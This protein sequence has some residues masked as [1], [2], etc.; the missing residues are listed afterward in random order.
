MAADAR[1]SRNSDTTSAAD[2]PTLRGRAV[3]LRQI[4]A[5][6]SRIRRIE[7]FQ[8]RSLRHRLPRALQPA[9]R[10]EIVRLHPSEQTGQAGR[11]RACL[12]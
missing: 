10:G 5:R 8:V 11:G 6:P 3:E 1:P 7:P 4:G 9:G 12:G 2:L